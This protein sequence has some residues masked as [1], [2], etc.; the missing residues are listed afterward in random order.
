MLHPY[1]W[2][3]R[4]VSQI[5]YGWLSRW[6][7]VLAL[8]HYL[9]DSLLGRF[10]KGKHEFCGKDLLTYLWCKTVLKVKQS[11]GMWEKF[12]KLVALKV[13]NVHSQVIKG[14]LET[15]ASKA[16]DIQE[17]S[18]LQSVVCQRL[19]YDANNV[20]TPSFWEQVEQ[21]VRTGGNNRLGVHKSETLWQKYLP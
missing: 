10:N 19:K 13:W 11:P 3:K 8:R 14:K 7:K 12:H 15:L 9:K 18:K 4:R 1:I 20:N 5:P 17:E 21:H 2:L 6:E 16:A